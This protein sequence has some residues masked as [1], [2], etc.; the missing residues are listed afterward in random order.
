MYYIGTIQN[1]TRSGMGMTIETI[2]K[3]KNRTFG[4]V[5]EAVARVCLSWREPRVE[6]YKS[7]TDT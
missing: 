3:K 4:K 6:I 5:C 1:K 2:Y 7:L